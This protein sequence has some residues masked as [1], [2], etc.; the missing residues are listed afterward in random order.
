MKIHTTFFGYKEAQIS[1]EATCSTSVEVWGSSD[2]N[3]F[4]SLPEQHVA[5]V[6]FT[7]FILLPWK[8]ENDCHKE[9]QIFY[10]IFPK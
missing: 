2:K 10:V 8:E 1:V 9:Q 7:P 6:K 3:I 5:S 4:P